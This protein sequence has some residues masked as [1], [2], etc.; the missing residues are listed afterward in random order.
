MI[1]YHVKPRY[2][3]MKKSISVALLLLV[4]ISAFS[5]AV[6][7]WTDAD[8]ETASQLIVIGSLSNVRDL[9]EV[10]AGLWQGRNKLLGLEATFEV[11]KVLKGNFTNRTVVLHYYRW[12]TPY[13][14][15]DAGSSIGSDVN[16][17][18]LIYLNPT[19]TNHF[20][21]YLVKDGASRYAPASGQLDSAS[22]AVRVVAENGVDKNLT[23]QISGILKECER[24]KPGMTRADLL[25]IFTTEGGLSTQTGRTFVHV[26]CP[27]IK[28]D[29]EFAP[30]ESRQE[31]PSDTVT[32]ISKPYLEW[33]V[34]D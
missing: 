10:N 9:D 21:L 33:S 6:R 26:R 15:S 16:S 24:L 34:A 3:A 32:K 11:S 20:I 2:E 25:K 17:P 29:V 1:H 18:G 23:Q 7:V 14:T 8:L 12:D 28:V 19:N 5:R 22:V 31:Q 27:C 13:K 30:T 4:G